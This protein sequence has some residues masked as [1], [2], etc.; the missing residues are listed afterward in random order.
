[1]SCMETNDLLC[2]IHC[3]FV[4]YDR[5]FAVIA[6][7]LHLHPHLHLHGQL[8]FQERERYS[9]DDVFFSFSS[10]CCIYQEK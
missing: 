1:M 9:I 5:R 8:A 4:R 6:V 7:F 2:D 3:C 10:L